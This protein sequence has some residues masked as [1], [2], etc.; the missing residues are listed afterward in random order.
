MKR[1]LF[2]FLILSIFYIYIHIYVADFISRYG[3]DRNRVRLFFLLLCMFSVSVLFLRRFV[4]GEFFSYLYFLG[5]MWM[6][7]VFISAFI[8]LFSDVALKFYK[9]DVRYIFFILSGIVLLSICASFKEPSVREITITSDKIKRDYVFYFLSDVH[10]DFKFKTEIFYRIMKKLDKTDADFIIIGGDLFDPGFVME[11]RLKKITSKKVFFVMGN[12]EY[13]FGIDRSLRCLHDMEFVNITSGSYIF[14]DINIIGI[15]DIK[16]KDLS[17][18]DVKKTV[19]YSYKKD[20]F[21]IVVSHQPL[22]FTSIGSIGQLLMISGHTHCGQIFPF[23]VF[24]K[25]F[26]PWF[27]GYYENNG[28]VLYVSSGAGVWGPPLRFFSNN[29]I[30]RFNLKRK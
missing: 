19:S 28:S 9:F 22:Y 3:F 13:Y 25:I 7:I 16:T 21:N 6:G 27:C 2:I 26:Y 20:L 23:H 30:V 11:D 24:T 10:L 5:F 14:E 18:E 4:Y 8:F 17:V 12:H 1:F 15:D 29:E